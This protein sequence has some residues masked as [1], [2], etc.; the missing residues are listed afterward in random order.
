MGNFPVTPGGI[1]CTYTF[2]QYK[3][4]VPVIFYT[5][6]DILTGEPSNFKI[7]HRVVCHV[8]VCV[9]D[10]HLASNKFTAVCLKYKLL[11]LQIALEMMNFVR[12]SGA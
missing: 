8:T 6:Y 10:L 5:A 7:Y 4:N 1:C 12:F 9:V 11:L 3:I 2:V